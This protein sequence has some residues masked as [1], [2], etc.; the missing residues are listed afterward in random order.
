[1]A[2]ELAWLTA[3]DFFLWGFLKSKVYSNNPK[4]LQDL[5]TNIIDEIGKITPAMLKKVMENAYKR[6]IDCVK[7]K[8]GHLRDI[9]FLN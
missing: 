1:M 5:K 8:G 3:P 4:T 6:A 9:I 2:V 7:C